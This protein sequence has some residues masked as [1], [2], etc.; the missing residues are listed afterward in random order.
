MMKEVQAVVG[1]A[2]LLTRKDVAQLNGISVAT[3]KRDVKRGRLPEIAQNGRRKRYFPA[4][5]AAY[6]VGNYSQA[7]R[8]HEILLAEMT[9]K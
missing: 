8:I 7:A 3:V 5:V 6:L 9:T 2:E 1:L 4:V